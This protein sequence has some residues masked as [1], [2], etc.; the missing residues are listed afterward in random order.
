MKH[1][2][3]LP[4]LIACV[5]CG[6]LEKNPSE[7]DS[8]TPPTLPSEPEIPAVRTALYQ[9][10]SAIMDNGKQLSVTIEDFGTAF[11][12]YHVRLVLENGFSQTFDADGSVTAHALHG[13]DDA[14]KAAYGLSEETNYRIEFFP[15]IN[16]VFV[17]GVGDLNSH[18]YSALGVPPADCAKI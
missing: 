2:L 8:P 9:C 7:P 4:L 18:A 12:R 3:L 16:Q 14:I 10:F 11:R 5:S 6:Y 15:K 13:I 1:L 17:N